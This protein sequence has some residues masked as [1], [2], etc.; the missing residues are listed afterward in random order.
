MERIQQLIS[1]LF[2]LLAGTSLLVWAGYFN[3]NLDFV[4]LARYAKS[5]PLGP[6]TGPIVVCFGLLFVGWMIYPSGKPARDT[7]KRR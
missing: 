7:N 1:V 5:L 6:D 3:E 2:A 4:G